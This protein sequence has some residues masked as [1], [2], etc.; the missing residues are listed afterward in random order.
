MRTVLHV[1]ATAQREAVSIARIVMAASRAAASAGY[2]TRA[3]FMDGDGP[4]VGRLREA[5]VPADV[6]YW[7][8]ARNLAG[9]I[10]SWRY[11]RRAAPDIVHQ[12]FGSEY[13]RGLI[14]AAG[15]PRIVA[16]FHD[17]GSEME[18]GRSVPHSAL[19]ADAAIA[20]SHSVAK[21]VRGRIAP[22]VVYP[23]IVPAIDR[24][25]LPL[26]RGP[27]VIGALSRLAPIKGYVHLVRA[28]PA[29]LARV[30]QARLEIAGEGPEARV[31]EA[32]AKRLGVASAV[33]L[34]GWRDD[35]DTL[36]AGWRV[37]AAP[38]LM[39]G[40]GLSTLEA[41]MQGLPIVA[42]CVGGIPELI[43]DGVSGLLVP[44]AEPAALAAALGDCLV[45]VPRAA[46]LGEHAALRARTIFAPATFDAAIRALY[47]GL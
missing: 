36:F 47:D 15:V 39:E 34:L 40:F 17:H 20:T 33:S 13:L 7:G 18:H 31:L 12:H 46:R 3:V 43:E 2:R 16:H 26:D 6:V 14:R 22:Q 37:F 19:F 8:R 4:L 44:P 5:G 35:L 11:L 27:P 21:L 45:D 29:V 30:P 10:R 38:S 42:S 24:P 32:E 41:A 9:N 1:L 25:A 28:M 23:A